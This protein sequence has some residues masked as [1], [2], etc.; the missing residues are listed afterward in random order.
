M[1]KLNDALFDGQP[2]LDLL[3]SEKLSVNT[4][5]IYV[6]RTGNPPVK[7]QP[8]GQKGRNKGGYENA[9]QSDYIE[10]TTTYN[11]LNANM[12]TPPQLQRTLSTDKGNNGYIEIPTKTNSTPGTRK[13]I[14]TIPEGAGPG[15]VLTV[16]APNGT[17]LSVSLFITPLPL[18]ISVHRGLGQHFRSGRSTTRFLCRKRYFSAV[19]KFYRKSCVLV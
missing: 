7:S 4:D 14:V 2:V 13:M 19:L 8:L 17:A 16:L 3:D 10:S 5:F 18:H 12:S 15:S 6:G 9:P 11:A 1:R